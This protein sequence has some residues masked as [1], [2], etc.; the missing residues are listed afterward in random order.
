V[1]AAEICALLLT[2][3]NLKGADLEIMHLF[4]ATPELAV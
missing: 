2:F 3:F 1:P 4:V